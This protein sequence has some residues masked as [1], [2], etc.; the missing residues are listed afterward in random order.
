MFAALSWLL[1]VNLVP[2]SSS[3]EADSVSY[4]RSSSSSSSRSNADTNA[5]DVP[6]A[7]IPPTTFTDARGEAVAELQVSSATA[8]ANNSVLQGLPSAARS[9]H[10]DAQRENALFAD[11]HAQGSAFFAS[12]DPREEELAY[13]AAS[14][15]TAPVWAASTYT[16]ET[17]SISP[18]PSP[19][20][21]Q[22]P[23]DPSAAFYSLAAH[24]GTAVVPPTSGVSTAAGRTLWASD[25]VV[26][27]ACFPFSAEAASGNAKGGGEAAN[28]NGAP[29]ATA[30]FAQGGQREKKQKAR[31][32]AAAPVVVVEAIRGLSGSV[33]PRNETPSALSVIVQSSNGVLHTTTTT[34]STA[35]RARVTPE[36]RILEWD[37]EV[38]ERRHL[39]EHDTIRADMTRLAVTTAELSGGEE[40]AAQCDVSS[41]QLV[42]HPIKATLMLPAEDPTLSLSLLSPSPA[43]HVVKLHPSNPFLLSTGTTETALPPP[44][45]TQRP[46]GMSHVPPT[47]TT[48]AM[49]TAAAAAEKEDKYEVGFV[50]NKDQQSGLAPPSFISAAAS[51]SSPP[52]ASA[53]MAHDTS[54]D[55]VL[56]VSLTEMGGPSV[57]GG[58][59]PHAFMERAL[60]QR[61]EELLGNDDAHTQRCSRDRSATRPRQQR[62]SS[63]APTRADETE[64]LNPAAARR[65]A[66]HGEAVVEL[67]NG[68][69]TLTAVGEKDAGQTPSRAVPASSA[70]LTNKPVFDF[71]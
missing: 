67:G 56:V 33:G 4:Q 37:Q 11:L 24:G 22:A 64:K 40:E 17:V 26:L 10:R 68:L 49:M 52:P 27:T 46:I 9:S 70:A 53:P 31:A 65:C 62:L 8:A 44:A 1:D 41:S 6:Q 51:S 19:A 50:S 32:A 13:S 15:Q 57:A 28:S 38:R 66:A 48:T 45:A 3:S 21:G 25:G 23:T 69:V 61:T 63:F 59:D 43:E 35:E 39:I 47:T 30:A 58:G 36:S 54:E 20:Y 71:S 29:A 42:P 18:L 2:S 60:R 16:S 34:M 55:S 12:A 7:V 5:T 14:L